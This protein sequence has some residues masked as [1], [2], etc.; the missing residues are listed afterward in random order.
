MVDEGRLAELWIY[1]VKACRGIPL[2]R[3]AIEPMGLAHDRRWMVVDAGSG[4]FLT[5][6]ETPQLAQVVP[7]IDGQGITLEVPGAE[8]L[9]LPA[10]G[11]APLGVRVWRDEVQAVAP[12]PPADAALSAL[13]GRAVRLVRFPDGHQR[14]CDP[15]HAPAG[16]H[17]GFA[18]GFPLLVTTQ[19]SLDQ[20]NARLQAAGEVAVPM[21]RF[22]PNLVIDGVPAGAEDRARTLHVG[23]IVVDLVKACDRCV[24]TTTDQVS[25]ERQGD[26]P[27][28]MLRTVRRNPRTRGVWFGQNGVPRL[29]RAQRTELKVGQPCRLL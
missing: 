1:P 6:R 27:L 22:R 7:I 21:T 24:V 23:G 26:Q 29:T 28:R 20:L 19:A 13:L 10:A 8:P 11:G 15:D 18:D 17:T 14:F 16:S 5:Q 9:R 3:S 12:S 4:R 25:G 2:Q